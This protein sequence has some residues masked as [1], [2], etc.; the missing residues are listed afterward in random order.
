MVSATRFYHNFHLPPYD[1]EAASFS[2]MP[3]TF[4]CS[5]REEDE[6]IALALAAADKQGILE[7]PVSETFT[8]TT[9]SLRIFLFFEMGYDGSQ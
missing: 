6:E 9:T 1:W 2:A 3:G 7:R 5:G 4:L 8:P